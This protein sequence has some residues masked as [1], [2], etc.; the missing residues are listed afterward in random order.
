MSTPN[1]Q[2]GTPP[3]P[4]AAAAPPPHPKPTV[5]RE[6]RIVSHCTLFYWWPVWFVGF[7]MFII[8]ATTGEYMVTVPPKATIK[9][10]KKD[11][12]GNVEYVLVVPE[13]HK[14]QIHKG[15]DDPEHKGLAKQPYL[16]MTDNKN[17]GVLFVMVL[18]LVIVITNIPLRGLW[19][20]I[21]IGLII[22]LSILFAW[23][24]WWNSILTWLSWLDIRINAAGYLVISVVLFVL[25]VV[26]IALF[27][28][29]MYLVLTPGQLRVRQ[30]I[31][32]AENIF[33][34][35][36]MKVQKQRNDF[37]RHWVL[38]MGSGDL[39]VKPANSEEIHMPNVLFIWIKV[40]KVEEMLEIRQIEAA[41]RPTQ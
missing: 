8:T 34:T 39:I 11:G 25:W 27:D 36:N 16:W 4:P 1:P 26:V 7:I 15:L 14:D 32:G 37:F 28:R 29:Q 24:E 9:E 38:G 12:K 3:T 20:T 35:T 18:L 17:L 13:P 5:K 22:T 19:S 10:P 33:D 21:V 2:P 6:V 31:G 23:L 41:G 30:E 40:K